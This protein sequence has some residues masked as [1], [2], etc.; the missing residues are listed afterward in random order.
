MPTH[1]PLINS[2]ESGV[3]MT[4]QDPKRCCKPAVARNT[5]PLTPTS[6]PST[7]TFG[8]SSMA[9]A[10]ARVIAST[11]VTSGIGAGLKLV[12]LSQVHLWKLGIE[13]I[14]HGFRPPWS[15]CEIVLDRRIDA[16]LALGGELFLVGL[17]PCLLAHEIGPQ[18]RDRLFLPMRLHVRRRTISARVIGSGV[19]AQPIGQGLDQARSLAGTGLL[20][21]LIRRRAH[22]DDIVAVHLLADKAGSNGF[23]GESLRCRLQLERYGNGPLIVVGDEHDGQLPDARKVHR[24]PHVTLGC[25]AIAEEAHRDSGLLSKSEGIGHARRM[26]GLG[27]DR[28]AVRK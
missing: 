25:R 5:P 27:A 4:R 14:E 6:S 23:L 26:R 2:S 13:V 19:V 21:R 17:A 7:T 24:L 15:G 28:D 12:A 22:R 16:L 1:R 8:S 10:S 11:N 3:S 20:D 9:R 18:A